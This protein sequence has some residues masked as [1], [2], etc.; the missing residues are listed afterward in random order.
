MELQSL[1]KALDL[2]FMASS[3]KD[4]YCIVK[5]EEFCVASLCHHFSGLLFSPSFCA[6]VV[7]VCVCVRMCT[8][9]PLPFSKC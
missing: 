2:C 9:T 6:Q 8:H 7:S 3:Y 5:C 4:S 1:Y